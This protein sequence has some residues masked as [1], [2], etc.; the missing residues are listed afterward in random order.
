M[1]MLPVFALNRA[2]SVPGRSNSALS[3]CPV[4]NGSL[5]TSR[6]VNSS[7]WTTRVVNSSQWTTSPWPTG[8]KLTVQRR[9]HRFKH[10]LFKRFLC[11]N[12]EQ[13]I[14][15]TIAHRHR[16]VLVSNGE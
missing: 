3:K 6:V 16:L 1:H 2:S 7:L 5:W 14:L 12:L 13:V 10:H 8:Q 15:L 9:Q 4:V 11:R